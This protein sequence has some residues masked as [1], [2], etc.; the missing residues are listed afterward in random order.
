MGNTLIESRTYRTLALRDCSDLNFFVRF[1]EFLGDFS[2]LMTVWW[3]NHD[4]LFADSVF[5]D[6]VLGELNLGIINI[7][8]GHGYKN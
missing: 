2:A 6:Q 5:V 8:Q 4:V 1:F 7:T 3:Q